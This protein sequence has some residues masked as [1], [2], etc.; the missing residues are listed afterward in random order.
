MNK[1]EVAE[2]KRR[3]KQSATTITRLCGCYVNAEKEKVLTFNKNFLNLPD[4][5]FY[6]Y[7]EIAKKNT[8][9]HDWK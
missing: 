3:F 6:K 9:R 7:L 5:E 8:F 4:E 1:K 2:I